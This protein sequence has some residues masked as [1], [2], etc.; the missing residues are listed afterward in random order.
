MT[1][2]VRENNM[3]VVFCLFIYLFFFGFVVCLFF[4]FVVCL[5][6]F[7]LVSLFVRTMRT[8]GTRGE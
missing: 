8:T 4:G 7:L 2:F 5:L 1:V 3:T 6:N